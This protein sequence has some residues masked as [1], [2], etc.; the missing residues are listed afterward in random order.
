MSIETWSTLLAL[1]RATDYSTACMA[2]LCP[3]IQMMT[4]FGHM[5]WFQA[6]KLWCIGLYCASLWYPN[7]RSQHV[8]GHFEDKYWRKTKKYASNPRHSWKENE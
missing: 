3:S 8:K 1:N 2:M 5:P 7:E 4:P 6:N